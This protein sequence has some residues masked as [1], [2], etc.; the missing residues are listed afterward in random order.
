MSDGQPKGAA[1]FKRRTWDKEFFA[2]K[3]R[4]RAEYAQEEE[5][6]VVTVKSDKEEFQ[7]ADVAAAGPAGSVR[8][9]LNARKGKVD[10]DSGVG[11]IKRTQDGKMRDGG[12]YCEVCEC[13]LKDSVAYLDHINGKKHQRKLGFSMRVA[14]STVSDVK[15]RLAQRKRTATDASPALD[16]GAAFAARVAQA[17]REEELE[18]QVS[19]LGIGYPSLN[20]DPAAALGTPYPETLPV[21]L[22]LSGDQKLVSRLVGKQSYED[23]VTALDAAESAGSDG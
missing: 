3:A 19:I 18:R 1:N 15:S 20:N 10:L 6:R 17:E 23:L 22:V 16:A 2:Q 14:S 8:A 9:F 7:A 11:K 13:V 12:Y 4:E 21:T 5:Q